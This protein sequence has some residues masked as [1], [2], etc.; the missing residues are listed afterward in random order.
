MSCNDDCWSLWFWFWF[1][2]RSINA[3]LKGVFDTLKPH[4]TNLHYVTASSL[5]GL[6]GPLVNP[7]VGGC[8]P[9]DLGAMDVASFYTRFLHTI[10]AD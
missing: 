2:T 5:F 4:D 9:S 3:A 10:L 6:T 7:T 1:W 8:H